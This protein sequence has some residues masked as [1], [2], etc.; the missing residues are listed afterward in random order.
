MNSPETRPAHA[1]YENLLEMYHERGVGVFPVSLLKKLSPRGT[2]A[3][4]LRIIASRF[5]AARKLIRVARGIYILPRGIPKEEE[6]MQ[7]LDPAAYISLESLLNSA[8]VLQQ[9]VAVLTC[10]TPKRD[11]AFDIPVRSVGGR[12]CAIPGARGTW[13]SMAG[14]RSRILF[15]HLDERFFTF[16]I[17]NGYEMEPEKALLDMIHIRLFSRRPPMPGG[18]WN[19]ERLDRKKMEA[20]AQKYPAPVRNFLRKFLTLEKSR[21]RARP[22][23]TLN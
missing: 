12:S 19:I 11:R 13:P 1:L 6:I 4:H 5:V 9:G 7:A 10:V 2:S 14:G 8:S 17:Q 22:V 3:E 16:G 18:N 23:A 21:S 15:H 20:Y